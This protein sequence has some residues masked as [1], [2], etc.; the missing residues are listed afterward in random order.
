MDDYEVLE[1]LNRRF[2]KKRERLRD[3]LSQPGI[4]NP[5]VIIQTPHKTA[6]GLGCSYHGMLI[7]KY[8]KILISRNPLEMLYHLLKLLL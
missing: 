1:V 6:A 4:L 8:L 3:R 5:S 7:L 2:C